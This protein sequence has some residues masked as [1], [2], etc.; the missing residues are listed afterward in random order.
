[1]V[2][3]TE[4]MT[5]Q[6]FSLAARNF[7]VDTAN[8]IAKTDQPR[9]GLM[10]RGTGIGMVSGSPRR[11]MPDC[12]NSPKAS[13]SVFV[14]FLFIITIKIIFSVFL[15]MGIFAGLSLI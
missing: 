3:G 5:R 1:M 15:E 6:S 8:R 9:F 14:V 7:G 13:D 4:I 10:V 2:N 11:S 12:A